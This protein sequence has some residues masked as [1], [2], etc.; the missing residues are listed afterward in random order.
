MNII[1]V[2]GRATL[3]ELYNDSA[4]TIEG[5][6]TSE[7]HLKELLNWIME[8]SKFKREDVY[9]ISGSLM[10]MAYGLTGDNAYQRDCNIVCIKLSDLE[11][12]MDLAIPRFTIGGRWFDDVVENN[13]RRQNEINGY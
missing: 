8:Y 4:F 12:P 11:S 10:N 1:K 9:V 6:D 5:Y 13:Q 7:E 3:T 2:E